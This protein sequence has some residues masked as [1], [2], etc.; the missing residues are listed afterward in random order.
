MWVPGSI[1]MTIAILVIVYRWL[2]PNR[3][4]AKSGAHPLPGTTD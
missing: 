1:P 2:Q 3:A 4:R